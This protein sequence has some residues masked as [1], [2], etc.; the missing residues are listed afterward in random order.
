MSE[1]PAV[2]L[3]EARTKAEAF[4]SKIMPECR[5]AEIVGSIRRK[6]PMV[7]DIDIVAIPA[8]Q[9]FL[10]TIPASARGPAIIRTS[11]QGMNVDIYIATEETYG[12]L[13]LI[14]TGSAAHN[15]KLC[16]LAKRR[17]WQL[18]AN[19]DGLIM[20]GNPG[21]T[22]HQEDAILKAILGKIPTPEEREA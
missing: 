11:Y 20:P 2:P 8:R 19:G 7:H 17:G 1:S 14:R 4:L 22:F 5:R 9:P 15:I 16:G 6:R 13:R 10:F 3:E 21:F 12:C 18:K